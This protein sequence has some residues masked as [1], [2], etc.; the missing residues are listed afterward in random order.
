[1]KRKLAYP[2]FWP[3]QDLHRYLSFFFFLIGTPCGTAKL[4]GVHWV[5]VDKTKLD[6]GLR[7]LSAEK[8]SGGLER[9][10]SLYS[11]SGWVGVGSCG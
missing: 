2:G 9:S 6:G 8:R 10:A 1:M 3:S 4:P 7:A 5:A 11:C